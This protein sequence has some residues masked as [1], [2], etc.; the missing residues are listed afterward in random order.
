MPGRGSHAQRLGSW[1][2][3][4]IGTQAQNWFD[5]DGRALGDQ[6]GVS[7][8]LGRA[9]F[10]LKPLVGLVL[11]SMGVVHLLK[12]DTDLPQDPRAWEPL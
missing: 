9:G 2:R 8:D 3:N 11:E 7:D 4:C 1:G 6:I 12:E 5:S 10:I